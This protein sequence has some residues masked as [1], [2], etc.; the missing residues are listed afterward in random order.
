MKAKIYFTLNMVTPEIEVDKGSELPTLRSWCFYNLKMPTELI[1]A[2]KI[3]KI[4]EA[5]ENT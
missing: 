2:I 1:K 5:N 4:E 3:E